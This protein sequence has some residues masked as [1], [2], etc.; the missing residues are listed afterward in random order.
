MFKW[1]KANGKYDEEKLF[2]AFSNT[3]KSEFKKDPEM[4]YMKDLEIAFFPI[5]AHEHDYLVVFNFMKGNKVIIDNS[6][7]QMTYEAKYKTVCELL[8]KLFSMYLEKVKHP[9]AKDVLNK[10]PTIIRPK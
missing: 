2:E 3:I 5:T 4:E 9:R 1:K 6:N 7:T 10:K 8:K